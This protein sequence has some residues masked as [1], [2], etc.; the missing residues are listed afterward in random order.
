MKWKVISLYAGIVAVVIAVLGVGYLAWWLERS[1]NY[2]NAYE[3]KVHDT[4][5]DMV[6][7]ECL[8]VP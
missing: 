6:K 1:W 5:K 8:R 4:V 7:P 3:D 2:S